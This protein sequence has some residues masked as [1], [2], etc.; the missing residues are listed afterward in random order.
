MGGPHPQAGIVNVHET[1]QDEIVGPVAAWLFAL[2]HPVA[3]QA[4][5]PEP[6]VAVGDVEGFIAEKVRDR[7]IL[8][9]F[10]DALDHAVNGDRPH[11]LGPPAHGVIKRRKL[12]VRVA[13]HHEYR[14]QL[15]LGMFG[16]RQAVGHLLVKDP[17]VVQV[18]RLPVLRQPGGG[19]KAF[20]HQFLAVQ[21]PKRLGQEIERRFGVLFQRAL[22]E[23]RVQPR[24]RVPV[25]HVALA[26]GKQHM[27]HVERTARHQ[28]CALRRVDHVVRRRDRVVVRSRHLRVKSKGAKSLYFRHEWWYSLLLNGP[29]KS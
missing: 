11:I 4:G 15:G 19:K 13:V 28:F 25:T 21:A 23:P 22:R 14:P 9:H 6:V 16:Q 8:R 1:H 17:L 27:H 12:P 10:P 29:G 18:T 26:L 7:L 3:V 2:V 5:H 24:R 20:P